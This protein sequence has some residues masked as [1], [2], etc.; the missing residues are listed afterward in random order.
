ML[1]V[2]VDR[3]RWFRGHGKAFSRLRLTGLT[4]YNGHMCCLG[5][6]MVAA[7]FDEGLDGVPS[8][9]VCLTRTF[10]DLVSVPTALSGLV[11][12]D[13]KHFHNTHTCLAMMD[14]N[15]DTSLPEFVREEEITKLGLKAGIEFTFTG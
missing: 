4:E 2:E 8:P 12:L 7:G 1:K 15:D 6:A 11:E 5:F 9:A 13:G 10:A 3:S 14:E